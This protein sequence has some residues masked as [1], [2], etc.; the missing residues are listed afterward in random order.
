MG[1]WNK[2]KSAATE[3]GTKFELFGD[4]RDDSLTEYQLGGVQILAKM[5]VEVE[6]MRRQGQLV[7]QHW[8]GFKAEGEEGEVKVWFD[9]PMQGIELLRQYAG[10]PTKW[11]RIHDEGELVEFE[12]FSGAPAK[13]RWV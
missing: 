11:F 1:F 5:E 8:Y 13:F 3:G 12:P 2:K 10:R 6:V 9:Q 7:E 4:D